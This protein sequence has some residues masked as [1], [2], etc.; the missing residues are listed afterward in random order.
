MAKG[1]RIVFFGTPGI[2]VASLQAILESGFGVTGVVTIP[3]R[4][5]GRGLKL[6][7]SPV[8]DFA[9]KNSLDLLQPEDLTDPGFLRKLR[10]WDPE[11]QVVVAFRILPREVW[12]LPPRGTFNLHASL[13]PQYRGAAPIHRV[14]MNGE[15]ETGVTTF[16]LQDRV[17]TGNLL[18]QERTPIGPDETAGELRDRLTTLGARLVVATLRQIEAGSLDPVLQESLIRP[19]IELKKAP[20]I[21]RE[22]CLIRWDREVLALHD[23]VRGLSPDPAAYAVFRIKGERELFLKIFRARPEVAEHGLPPGT[24]TSDGKTFLKVAARNGYLCLLSVQPS[25]RKPM[26]IEEFLHGAGRQ[27]L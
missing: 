9:V 22:D 11:V 24:V 13:L 17:D 15:K 12:A 23:Q 7:A 5:A 2:A 25:G 21:A 1:L 6:T 10:D 20:K 3:D 27:L 14:L 18:L 26:D 4:P 19:G 16:F 8:K